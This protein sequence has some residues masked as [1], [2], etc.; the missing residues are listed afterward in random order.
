[1]TTQRLWETIRTRWWWL[2]AGLVAGLALGALALVVLPQTYRSEAAILVEVAPAD[3]AGSLDVATYVDERLP[4]YVDLGFG[5]AA[6]EDMRTE[7]GEDLS[8]QQ[9]ESRVTY[10]P[11]DGSLVIA[12]EGTGSSAE[13]AQAMAGAG[14]VALG[15]AISDTSTDTV[16]VSTEPVQSATLPSRP[17]TPDPQILLPAGAVLGLLVALLAALVNG[18]RHRAVVRNGHRS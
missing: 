11:T 1:M 14:A 6:L 12:I 4:T 5:D 2:A 9:L 15:T 8:R 7:L 17:E 18:P 3:D 16:E 13:N 10:V